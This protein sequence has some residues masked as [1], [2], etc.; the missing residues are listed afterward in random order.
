MQVE[1][2]IPKLDTPKKRH[3]FFTVTLGTRNDNLGVYFLVKHTTYVVENSVS[4][5]SAITIENGYTIS[6]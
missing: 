5:L 4:I 3:F 1:R 2:K 6:K